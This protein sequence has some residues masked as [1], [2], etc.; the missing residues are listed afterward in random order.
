MRHIR[1]RNVFTLSING[2]LSWQL[3]EGWCRKNIYCKGVTRCRLSRKSS[4]NQVGNR[5]CQPE[6]SC[7]L[8][9][10][11]DINSNKETLTCNSESHQ[12]TLERCE[13]ALKGKRLPHNIPWLVWISEHSNRLGSR[14]WLFTEPLN[15]GLRQKC[16]KD[17]ICT[18]T[19]KVRKSTSYR[20]N[21][22]TAKP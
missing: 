20:F 1:T 19:E 15:L 14:L 9:F 2:Q 18:P 8:H 17:V 4:G 16:E 3:L 10:C 12:V 11:R 7:N 22:S 21:W 5:T 13:V 6:G